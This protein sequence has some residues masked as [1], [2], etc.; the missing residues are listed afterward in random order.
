MRGQQGLISPRT[1]W[2]LKLDGRAELERLRE[3]SR[4]CIQSES[5]L[6][7]EEEEEECCKGKG[8]RIHQI[9]MTFVT[10]WD[11]LWSPTPPPQCRLLSKKIRSLQLNCPLNSKSK[12]FL[13][14]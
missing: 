14:Q 6:E 11:I 8:E 3:E 5:L 10:S 13:Q 7:E 4:P 2:H 12:D 9:Q 1:R